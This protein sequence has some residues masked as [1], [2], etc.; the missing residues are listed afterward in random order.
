MPFFWNIK[1]AQKVAKYWSPNGSKSS[2]NGDK[3]PNL[4]QRPPKFVKYLLQGAK[5]IPLIYK[6]SI[7]L[8][9]SKIA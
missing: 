6:Y 2:P 1:V 5:I 7:F 4:H 3:L 9:N 8:L